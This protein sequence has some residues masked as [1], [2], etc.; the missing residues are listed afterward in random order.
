M[1]N[2]KLLAVSNSEEGELMRGDGADTREGDG[3]DDEDDDGDGDGDGDADDDDVD[4]TATDE[5]SEE[6]FR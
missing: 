4:D 5:G 2:N 6:R 1:E 3:D